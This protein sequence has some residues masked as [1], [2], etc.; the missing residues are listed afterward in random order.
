MKHLK[1]DERDHN[2]IEGILRVLL[3]LCGTGAS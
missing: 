1:G 3:G 2:T